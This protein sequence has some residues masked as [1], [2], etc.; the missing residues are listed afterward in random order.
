MPKKG[1]LQVAAVP[2]EMDPM[3][4]QLMMGGGSME[5]FPQE[6]VTPTKKVSLPIKRRTKKTKK[7]KKG[8]K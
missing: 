8:K 3:I 4:N 7:T 5:S 2:E 6:Q 1:G